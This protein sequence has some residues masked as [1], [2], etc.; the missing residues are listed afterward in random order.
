MT[1]PCG[2]K[3]KNTANLTHS[4]EAR[5][6][7]QEAAPSN[8]LFHSFP[9]FRRLEHTPKYAGY[10]VP[11]DTLAANNA[12]HVG[13]LAELEQFRLRVHRPHSHSARTRTQPALA[14]RRTRTCLVDPRS[15]R[16][17]ARSRRL[18]LSAWTS[19]TTPSSSVR[20]ATSASAGRSR[21]ARS[22]VASRSA[23]APSSTRR[24][25]YAT[26]R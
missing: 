16:F 23:H 7:Q 6:W 19:I 18:L 1:S 9:K 25:R 17:P 3:T 14:P 26:S 15:G 20:T 13:Q 22:T 24:S 10:H 8:T 5:V 11:C 21:S 2:P 4:S 12:A